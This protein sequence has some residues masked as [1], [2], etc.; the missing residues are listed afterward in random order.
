[1]SLKLSRRRFV[2]NICRNFAAN[3]DIA[4]LTPEQFFLDQPPEEFIRPFDP[5]EFLVEL[6][7]NTTKS[8]FKKPE[9]NEIALF[10]G[11]PGAGKSTFFSRYLKPLGYGRI[12]QD[13]LKTVSVC[14]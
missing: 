6:P 4:Y 2:V 11:P 12:N 7:S 14:H 10:V 13:L 3:V 5:S 1:V 9:T 8:T